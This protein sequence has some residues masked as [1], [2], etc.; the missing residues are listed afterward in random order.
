[1]QQNSIFVSNLG[2]K[3]YVITYS[4]GLRKLAISKNET[5]REL[6][7]ETEQTKQDFIAQAKGLI[8]KG[9]IIIKENNQ[10]KKAD[11]FRVNDIVVGQNK[12]SKH[13]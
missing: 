9:A 4:K 6:V 2:K 11:D 5:L 12:K 1:M 3:D 13:S 8:D 7:F 10:P